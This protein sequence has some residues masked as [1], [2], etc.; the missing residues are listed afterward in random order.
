MK[1]EDYFNLK[2]VKKNYD[3]LVGEYEKSYKM[4]GRDVYLGFVD[5]KEDV[6]E[7]CKTKDLRILDISGHSLFSP[8]LVFK[9]NYKEYTFFDP[10]K[11]HKRINDETLNEIGEDYKIFYCGGYSRNYD[12]ILDWQGVVNFG[13]DF[14][15]DIFRILLK[16]IKNTKKYVIFEAKRILETSE[17]KHLPFDFHAYF[18]THGIDFQ[19]KETPEWLNDSGCYRYVLEV[20]K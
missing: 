17:Y 15:Y 2:T 11:K 19:R 13:D 4:I 9:N 10:G 8:L 7:I 18:N 3:F 6:V 1:V 14:K 5:Y 20:N 16:M 12:L